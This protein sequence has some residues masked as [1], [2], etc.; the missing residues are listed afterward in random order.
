MSIGGNLVN[1]ELKRRAERALDLQ[2]EIT[3]LQE[4]LKELFAEAKS[5]GYDMKAFKQIIKELRKGPEFQQAQ[6]EL[7][8]ILDTY[9]RGVNLPTTL[10]EAQQAVGEDARAVP[11]PKSEKRKRGRETVQ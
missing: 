7:E 10:E 3:A 11:E 5:D 4:D 9:R 8:L 1:E 2:G 6:L